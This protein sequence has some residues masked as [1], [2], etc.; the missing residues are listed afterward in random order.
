M[1][2]IVA[3]LDDCRIPY[4]AL[5]NVIKEE[6]CKG[7]AAINWL[8]S[9]L[10]KVHSCQQLTLSCLFPRLQQMQSQPYGTS[11]KRYKNWNETKEQKQIYRTERLRKYAVCLSILTQER[12]IDVCPAVEKNLQSVIDCT[13]TTFFFSGYWHGQYLTYLPLS[14][15]RN[16]YDS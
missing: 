15:L 9:K 8:N 12:T 5:M 4:K 14:V 7:S 10:P 16:A 1:N 3:R 13:K 6:P 11:V 2:V